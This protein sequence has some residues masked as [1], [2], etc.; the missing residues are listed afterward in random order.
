[1]DFMPLN[2]R[3]ASAKSKFAIDWFFSGKKD[4]ITN[5]KSTLKLSE[6]LEPVAILVDPKD[7]KAVFALCVN[8]FEIIHGHGKKNLNSLV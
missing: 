7:S 6:D 5:C 1:M 3:S 2:F 4:E 8:R